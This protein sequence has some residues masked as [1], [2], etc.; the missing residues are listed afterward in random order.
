MADLENTVLL[1]LAHSGKSTRTPRIHVSTRYE[2]PV[3]QNSR[4]TSTS[5]M[6]KNAHTRPIGAVRMM[7]SV[8]QLFSVVQLG[9]GDRLAEVEKRL[10][11]ITSVAR[12]M[13][14]CD[15]GHQLVWFLHRVPSCLTDY[16]MINLRQCLDTG[17]S[18]YHGAVADSDAQ[19]WPWCDRVSIQH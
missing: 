2:A 19:P 16:N 11:C 14:R 9:S 4:N 3:L 17:G 10:R 5:I 12:L 1:R 6:N 8:S 7:S 15:P 13:P 18:L